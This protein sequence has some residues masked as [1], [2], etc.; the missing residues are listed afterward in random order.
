MEEFEKD[1]FRNRVFR[2]F[3]G[4]FS[5]E[6]AVCEKEKHSYLLTWKSRS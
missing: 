1:F 2:S 5:R 6:F 4:V 3:Y